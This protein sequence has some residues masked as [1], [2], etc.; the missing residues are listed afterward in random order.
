[1]NTEN[2]K[3]IKPSNEAT[4]TDEQIEQVVEVL[5]EN[6]NETDELLLKIEEEYKDYDNSND[7]LEDGVGEYVSDG[8]V[9][10][11]EEDED[12]EFS[13]LDNLD[14][15]IEE[16]YDENIKN[17]ISDKLEISDEEA[18]N[19]FDVIKKV[20]N[21]EPV[22]VYENLPSKLKQAVEKLCDQ[23]KV[24]P[25]Y[26]DQILE[27]TAKNIINEIINESV[28]S[29]DLEKAMEEFLPSTVGELYT[30]TN[31]EYIEEEFPKIV[32]QIKEE[33]PKQAENLMAMR[34]GFIHSYTFEP[35]YEL[36][37]NSKVVKNVR[38]SETLWN[39]VDG[40]YK[41]VAG[42][43]KFKLY[44]LSDLVDSL[45]K[46]GYTKTQAMRIIAL[47][48]YTYTNGIEDYKNA[49]EYDDIYRNAFANYFEANVRNLAIS[50]KL[51]SDFSKQVKDNLQELSNHIDSTISEREA[52]QS[53]KKKKKG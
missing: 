30:E 52:Q 18:L 48:V 38:R 9:L 11:L 31:K 19:L 5:E 26:K 10:P 46:I 43:C 7:P 4:I 21:N 35:M 16:L 49:E 42:V 34:Q 17:I 14:S 33:H 40:E 13:H 37:K 41:R 2:I 23:E 28:M 25:L 29:L 44:P 47:F 1:M 32:E 20:Q 8:V 3:E 36:L 39:R 51:V 50:P 45:I 27:Y 12:D 15:T 22:K 53:N 24:D 6:R